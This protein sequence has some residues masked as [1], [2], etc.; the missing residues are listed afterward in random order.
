MKFLFS[1]ILLFITLASCQAQKEPTTLIIVRHAEKLTTGDDPG[2]TPI[3]QDRAD[4]LAQMLE[5][6]TITAVYS[7]P[8][9]RTQLTGVPTAS[10]N[11]LEVMEYDP[12][13][14][15]GF[16]KEVLGKHSGETILITGHS[17]TVPA[18]VNLLTGSS[19][20]NFTD[21]DYGNL[22]VI[23]GSELGG[24]SSLNLFF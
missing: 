5:R 14:A 20:E 22:F 17:N 13:D 11:S 19:M 2:L 23:T 24:C 12:S 6:Q 1:T 18:M 8:Y 9:Q 7:T 16:L 10:G 15:E 4:R 21:D 3:G